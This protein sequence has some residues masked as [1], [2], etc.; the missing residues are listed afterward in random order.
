MKFILVRHGETVANIEKVYSGWS[1]YEL[2]EK[3]RLQIKILAEELRTYKVDAIYASSLGR[4]ME[5][6]KEIGKIYSVI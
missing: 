5:T 3:G 1:N 4:T 2:T 6:A